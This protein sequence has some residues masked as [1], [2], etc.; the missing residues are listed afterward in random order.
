[1]K[2][3]IKNSESLIFEMTKKIDPSFKKINEAESNNYD[4]YYKTLGDAI[5]A[6]VNMAENKGYEVDDHELFVQFGTGGIRYEETKSAEIS[7]LK[8]GKPQKEAL[9]ISIYR[10]PSG[11]YELTTYIN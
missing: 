5:D 2:K 8:N 7:L 6:A 3:N 4:L 11:N 1:M 10:M 9:H